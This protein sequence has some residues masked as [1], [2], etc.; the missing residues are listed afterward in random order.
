MIKI[1][2]IIFVLLIPFFSSAQELG[3][4]AKNFSGNS[5]NGEKINL[6]DYNGKIILLDFW[7]SWCKPCKEEFPFLIELFEQNSNNNFIVLAV[8]IDTDIEN[9]KKFVNNLNKDVS[10]KIIF[11]P[12]SKIPAIYN[13]DSMPSVIVIDKKGVIRYIHIGFINSD[14]EKYK[15]EIETL[16]NE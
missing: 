13:I 2:L 15:K 6:S 12:D 14:K 4:E 3:K 10:F 7:A 5:L 8:N 1:L 16:L 9:L 11:D